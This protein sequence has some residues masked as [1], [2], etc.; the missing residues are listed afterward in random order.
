MT[1]KTWIKTIIFYDILVGMK[2]TMSHMLH[3]RPVTLQ[4]PHE[5]RTLPDNYRGMLALLRYDDGTEKCVGCDLCEAACPSRV[6]RVVSAEVPGEPTKRYSKEYYMDMTRC[7][8][9]GLCVDACPVD[10][11]GMTREFEWSVYDKRQLHLNKEQL[12]AIGDRSFPVREKQL[13]LQHPNVAFFNVAF[14]NLPQKPVGIARARLAGRAGIARWEGRA[15]LVVFTELPGI[16]W[17]ARRAF[18]A[19]L[20]LHVWRFVEPPD[21]AG[22]LLGACRTGS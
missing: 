14:K 5:K 10:A 17:L 3:Y 15:G 11:L 7:L 4:Y 19:C 22:I 18:L 13:D 6:I 21:V 20:A 2:A 9:C 12:L 16:G 8:F 1:F